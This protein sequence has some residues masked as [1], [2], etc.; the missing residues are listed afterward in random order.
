MKLC[1]IY[2]FA[3]HYRSEIFQLFDKGFECD[4]YFGD[5][6]FDVK[7]VGYSVLK[8]KITAI[9]NGKESSSGTIDG[10]EM[11]IKAESILKFVL[12]NVT[13][14]A[15]QYGNYAKWQF[16]QGCTHLLKRRVVA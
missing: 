13:M 16:E 15:L 8:G 9:H 6:Y 2:N 7:K 1:I 10:M 11:K 5:N 4:F 3:Q 14:G 12:Y